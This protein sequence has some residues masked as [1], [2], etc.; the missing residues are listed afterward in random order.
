MYD[1]EIENGRKI[2]EKI[3]KF[4]TLK[5]KSKPKTSTEFQNDD[6][7]SWFEFLINPKEK[8]KTNTKPNFWAKI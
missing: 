8:R 2:C 1:D 7:L 4:L 3:S 6:V 5:L